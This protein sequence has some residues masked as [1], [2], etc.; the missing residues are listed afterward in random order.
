MV[1]LLLSRLRCCLRW[2]LQGLTRNRIDTQDAIFGQKNAKRLV[3]I[4][5]ADTLRTM[6][7]RTLATKY[8]AKDAARLIQRRLLTLSKDEKEIFHEHDPMPEI[9][10]E[11]LTRPPTS[12]ISEQTVSPAQSPVATTRI[13]P[14][15]KVVQIEDMPM[16]A[17]D[18]VRA[19]VAHTLKRPL[20][21]ITSKESIKDHAKGKISIHRQITPALRW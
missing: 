7:Q 18:V 14:S 17:I 9:P 3:E 4:G 20:S 8:E 11:P 1:R 15:R 16:M 12:L 13:N 5:P 10:N 6:A 19:L 2:S 21:A